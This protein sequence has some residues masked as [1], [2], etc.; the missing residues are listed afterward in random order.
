MD[1]ST[2]LLSI[3]EEF[4]NPSLSDLI[5]SALKPPEPK[6]SQEELEQIRRGKVRANK[7]RLKGKKIRGDTKRERRGPDF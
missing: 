1:E 2:Y 6:Y 5:S 4:F 3:E 7:E